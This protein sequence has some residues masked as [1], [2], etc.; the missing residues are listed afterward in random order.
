MTLCSFLVTDCIP[1]H[2]SLAELEVDQPEVFGNLC[3]M[4]VDCCASTFL[5]PD[6]AL[7]DSDYAGFA[8]SLGQSEHQM[9]LNG[10]SEPSS[11]LKRTTAPQRDVAELDLRRAGGGE[12]AV[13]QSVYEEQV[14]LSSSPCL[15]RDAD[16]HEP[17]LSPNEERFVM[18]PVR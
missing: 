5:G 13:S 14:G 17:L 12:E 15:S 11:S 4:T 2:L 8:P 9:H 16:G 10:M 6:L 3:K 1:Q 18:Y 7:D